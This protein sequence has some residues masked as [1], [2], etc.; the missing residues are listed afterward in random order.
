[1][2]ARAL[3][4]TSAWIK[5]LLRR[6]TLLWFGVLLI[7]ARNT[8]DLSRQQI[9]LGPSLGFKGG[10][11]HRFL[12]TAERPSKKMPRKFLCHLLQCRFMATGVDGSPHQ[13]TVVNNVVVAVGIFLPCF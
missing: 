1:M 4:I 9:R 7:F 13:S 8:I 2:R 5:Q 11:L 3:R 10:K 6:L 12:L